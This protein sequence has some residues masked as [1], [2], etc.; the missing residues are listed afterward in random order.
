MD[1]HWVRPYEYR[2]KVD[3][4]LRIPFELQCKCGQRGVQS[5]AQAFKPQDGHDFPATLP[6]ISR[7]FCLFIRPESRYK[8]V[9]K[10]EARR[11]N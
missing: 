9:P 7:G 1:T 8:D 3:L 5:M 6:M 10:Y 11:I 4:V 2:I